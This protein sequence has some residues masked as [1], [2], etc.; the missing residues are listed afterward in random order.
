MKKTI[1]LAFTLLLSLVACQQGPRYTINGKMNSAE[2]TL[3]LFGFNDS[4]DKVTA[5]A[6]D[7]QGEFSFT[8]GIDTI[9]PLGLALPDGKVL[10]IFGEP[11]TE[12][13]VIKDSVDGNKWVVKGGKEQARYDSLATILENITSNSGRIIHI[14]NFIKEHPFSCVNIALIRRFLI[15]AESPNNQFIQSRIKNLGGTLQDDEFFTAMREKIEN[16]NSNTPH[17]MFPSFNTKDK[18]GKKITLKDYKDKLLIVNFWASWDTSSRAQMKEISKLYLA[19]DTSMVKM[20]NISLDYDT[21]TW[22]RCVEQDSIAG[23]NICDGKAWEGELAKRFS[24]PHLTFSMLVT[25]FQRIDMFNIDTNSFEEA[26]NSGIKNYMQKEK[27][28]KK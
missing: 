18:N 26:V 12:A 9:T 19:T 20:L 1:L 15:E 28:K 2:D 24:I 17:K 6:C 7:E 14:D 16:K 22:K 25:P 5:I 13:V 10:T 8:M 21:D 4:H 23:D 11:D 3:Y 27:K